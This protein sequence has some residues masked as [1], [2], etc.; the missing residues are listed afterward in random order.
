MLANH[1]FS[2]LDV[3]SFP[4]HTHIVLI[5]VTTFTIFTIFTAAHYFSTFLVFIPL[6][7]DV[8]GTID[9]N[10]N[11]PFLHFGQILYRRKVFFVSLSVFFA[12]S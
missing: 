1:A 4:A 10:C 5:L 11:N 6:D 7:Q 8:T 3:I 9:A 12:M 2:Y